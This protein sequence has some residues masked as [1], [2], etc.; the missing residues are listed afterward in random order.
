MLGALQGAHMVGEITVRAMAIAITTATVI[1]A[2]ATPRAAAPAAW[3][4]GEGMATPEGAEAIEVTAMG[5]AEAEEVE[6]R[7]S[8]SSL[9]AASRSTLPMRI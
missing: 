6:E 8:L 5:E 9:L 3:T 7:R 4:V 1:V 2:A